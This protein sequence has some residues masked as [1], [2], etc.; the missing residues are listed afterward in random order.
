MIKGNGFLFEFGDVQNLKKVIIEISDLSE[1][2]VLDM[3]ERSRSMF[4]ANWTLESIYN[5]WKQLFIK[6]DTLST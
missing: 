3:S 1:G 6:Y 2:E 4:E 5:R